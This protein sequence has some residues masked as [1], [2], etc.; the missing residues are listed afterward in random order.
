ML[1]ED[2]TDE[3]I[4][5]S[6]KKLNE[7]YDQYIARYGYVTGNSTKKFSFDPGYYLVASLEESISTTDPETGQESTRIEKAAVFTK[8]TIEPVR[9]PANAET[10]T[11]ALRISLCYRGKVDTPYL[12]QLIGKPA[13]QV[14]AELLDEGIAFD[15]PANGFWETAERYLSGNVREK[16]RI[17]RQAVETVKRYE[18]HVK[19][20]AAIQPNTVGI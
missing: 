5:Q 10:L 7:G 17:A 8:R 1:R 2:A 13:E 19:A 6:Q 4:I 20:L 9:P 14:Q 12:A 18:K 16:L 11:D 15:N 3:E